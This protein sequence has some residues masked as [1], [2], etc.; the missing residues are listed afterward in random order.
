VVTVDGSEGAELYFM[1]YDDT[2]REIGEA[3]ADAQIGVL[4]NA[5]KL[6][7]L[8]RRRLAALRSFLR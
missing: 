5:W 4:R 6:P 8:M 1:P 3:L 7:L 2:L